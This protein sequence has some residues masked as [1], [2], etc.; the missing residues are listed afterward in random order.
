LAV[1]IALPLATFCQAQSLLDHPQTIIYDENHSRYL[2]SCL[3]SSDIVQI[4]S[5]GEH[6]YFARATHMNAAM[7]ISGNIVYGTSYDDDRLRGYDLDTRALV[8]DVQIPQTFQPL[9]IAAD[10]AGHLYI[11]DFRTSGGKIVKFRI[12]D[13]TFSTLVADLTPSPTGIVFDAPRN[14]LVAVTYEGTNHPILAVDATSAAVTTL[15]YTSLPE[16]TGI[17]K[18]RYGRFYVTVSSTW[19]FRFDAD[20]G[21]MPVAVFQSNCPNGG[22]VFTDY[23]P[24]HEVVAFTL[25]GWNSWGMIDV[26]PPT[27]VQEPPVSALPKKHDLEQNYPNPFNPVTTIQFSVANRLPTT[28]TVYDPLGREVTTLV[29]EVK[30]PG[31]YSVQWDASGEASGTYFCRL[32]AG[33]FTEMRKLILVK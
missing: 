1:V 23:N 15:A 17:T 28:L 10:H 18:D 20:F 6:S 2:L 25:C 21:S 9:G 27:G 22:I 5:T 12:S 8:L 32:Q 16:C 4:D 26:Y 24:R 29:N 13:R 19:L 11:T 33:N 30:E 31:T 7:T 3:M 14:R